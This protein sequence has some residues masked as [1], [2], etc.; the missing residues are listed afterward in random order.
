MSKFTSLDY[1]NIIVL[2]VIIVLLIIIFTKVSIDKKN[3]KKHYQRSKFFTPLQV[4]DSINNIQIDRN[5]LK[6]LSQEGQVTIYQNNSSI[7]IKSFTVLSENE[8]IHYNTKII[9][10]NNNN[11]IYTYRFYPIHYTNEANQNL[12]YMYNFQI[13]L[14]KISYSSDIVETINNGLEILKNYL[15]KNNSKYEIISF[16]YNNSKYNEINNPIGQQLYISVGKISSN[17]NNILY[18]YSYGYSFLNVNS[19]YRLC[20]LVSVQDNK[21]VYNK[22]DLN[23]PIILVKDITEILYETNDIK[24]MSDNI[25]PITTKPVT[26]TNS[27]NEYIYNLMI[28]Y[29]KLNSDEK[30]IIINDIIENKYY[31]SIIT[32]NNKFS[33][34]L[35]KQKM[36]STLNFYNVTFNYQV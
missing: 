27:M 2:I 5:R 14:S 3:S 36:S 12:I 10:K 9:F 4:Q 28:N 11:K 8:N 16:I 19:N 23:L 22:L 25:I 15:N 17:T 13:D 18:L 33:K 32:N 35:V 29:P 21:K 24:I 31:Y 1:I 30:V 7:P 26:V 34:N 6:N 20:K